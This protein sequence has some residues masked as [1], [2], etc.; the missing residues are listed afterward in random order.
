MSIANDKCPDHDDTII[1]NTLP[2]LF[3]CIAVRSMKQYCGRLYGGP[4][5]SYSPTVKRWLP[6]LLRA[7]QPILIS[8]AEH[9][10]SLRLLQ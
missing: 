1:L 6:Y 8:L 5:V 7:L 3:V 4:D 2:T 10:L 9:I